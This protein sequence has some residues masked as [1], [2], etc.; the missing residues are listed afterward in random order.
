MCQ[1]MSGYRI[2]SRYRDACVR[3]A[4]NF[5]QRIPPAPDSSLGGSSSRLAACVHTLGRNREVLLGLS[6]TREVT[7]LEGSGFATPR[8][9]PLVSV[10]L[11]SLRS[12][13][14]APVLFQVGQQGV[15]CGVHRHVPR[16]SVL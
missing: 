1:G 11:L 3:L 7:V 5:V 12:L 8:S 9:T 15:H 4:F 16:H 6:S 10:Y 13:A 2:G 14:V